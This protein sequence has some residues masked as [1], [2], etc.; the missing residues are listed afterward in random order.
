MKPTYALARQGLAG[1]KVSVGK[2]RKKQKRPCRVDKNVSA[3][4]FAQRYGQFMER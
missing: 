1:R 4:N 3:L 2:G